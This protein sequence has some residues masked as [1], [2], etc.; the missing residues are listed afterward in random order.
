MT[1]RRL[2]VTRLVATHRIGDQ[3]EVLV[4]AEQDGAPVETITLVFDEE[5][6]RT[7][8]P[9]FGAALLATEEAPFAA[10]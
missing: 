3:I 6:K 4:E 7:V 10:S 1:R 8:L 9:L 5:R 2:H